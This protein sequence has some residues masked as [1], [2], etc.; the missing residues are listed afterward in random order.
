MPFQ[1]NV[2]D[3]STIENTFTIV[4]AHNCAELR[5]TLYIFFVNNN[6]S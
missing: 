5:N 4:I 3:L 1:R 6:N 2:A